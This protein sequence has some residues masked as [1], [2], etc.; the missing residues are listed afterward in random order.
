ML[1]PRSQNPDARA[2]VTRDMLQMLLSEFD[3]LSDG[4]GIITLSM[5]GNG[6]YV[7]DPHTRSYTIVGITQLSPA[8]SYLR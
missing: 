2:E 8:M 3:S 7:E 5:H 6:L 4:Q 1:P